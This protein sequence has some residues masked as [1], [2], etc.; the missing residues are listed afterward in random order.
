M[1]QST[2]KP[3]RLAFSDTPLAPTMIH[4]YP[5]NNRP[6]KDS[7]FRI[8]RIQPA[9]SPLVPLVAKL[10]ICERE[11]AVKYEALSYVWGK[12]ESHHENLEILSTEDN[13]FAGNVSFQIKPNLASA[14]K[15]S[16]LVSPRLTPRVR[17]NM[18]ELL[19]IRFRFQGYA[20]RTS[21]VDG[22]YMH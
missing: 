3:L 10:N 18:G 19:L 1:S 13:P 17:L 21:T 4:N 2:C 6:I 9:S 22:C 8:L 5:Y 12:D 14:L 7:E 11:P 15:R 16:F 20:R